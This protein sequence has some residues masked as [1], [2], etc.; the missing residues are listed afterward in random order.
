MKQETKFFLDK[1]FEHKSDSGEY[2]IEYFNR[3][4]PELKKYDFAEI[5]SYLTIGNYNILG[6]IFEFILST[7]SLW[8]NYSVEDWIRVMSQLNPRPNPISKDIYIEGY[9]DIHFLCKYMRIN[10]I[11]LFLQ[12]RQFSNEEKKK[13]LRY[14]RKILDSLFMDEIDIEDLDGNYY[15]HKDELETIRSNLISTR[16]VKPLDCT[17]NELKAYIEKELENYL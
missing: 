7:P 1:L 3:F 4:L 14:C 10:A 17:E 16:K 6:Y 13:V 9:V 2:G 5:L 12:Q 15:I 8:K 11:D